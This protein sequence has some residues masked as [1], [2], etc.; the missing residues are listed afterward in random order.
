MSLQDDLLGAFETHSAL[1]T[2]DFF[3]C[4]AISHINFATKTQRHEDK[5]SYFICFS[6]CLGAFVARNSVELIVGRYWRLWLRLKAALSSPRF[7][8]A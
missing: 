7:A 2:V 1:Q 5:R 8:A 3:A 4:R 6:W